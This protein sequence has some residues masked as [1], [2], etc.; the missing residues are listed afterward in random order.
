[1]HLS[2]DLDCSIGYNRVCTRRAP[3]ARPPRLVRPVGLLADGARTAGPRGRTCTRSQV[4]NPHVRAHVRAHMRVL[5]R[6]RVYAR[7]IDVRRSCRLLSE[8]HG[9]RPS[10]PSPPCRVACDQ[11]PAAGSLAHPWRSKPPPSSTSQVVITEPRAVPISRPVLDA[12]CSRLPAIVQRAA[13]KPRRAAD[14]RAVEAVAER[15]LLRDEAAYPAGREALLRRHVHVLP[16]TCTCQL[17]V[18]VMLHD[19]YGTMYVNMYVHGLV[20]GPYLPCTMPPACTDQ[21]T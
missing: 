14:L 15:L 2:C 16:W 10:P 20:H 5:A 12:A 18:L 4:V 3:P 9:H 21:V 7:A 6:S 1:M 8:C 17:L 11:L 13:R 19:M